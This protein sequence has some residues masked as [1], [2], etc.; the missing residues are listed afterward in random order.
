M[1]DTNCKDGALDG[2]SVPRMQ[3]GFLFARCVCGHLR[4]VETTTVTGSPACEHCGATTADGLIHGPDRDALVAMM[5]RPPKATD[6]DNV[7]YF[8]RSGNLIK[9]GTT[10]A[11]WT[12]MANLGHPELLGVIP[13]GYQVERQHHE[14]FTTDKVHGEV[15]RA[16][17][18]LLA[19]IDQHC[20]HPDP[21]EPKPKAA[22]DPTWQTPGWMRISP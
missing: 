12:R 16:S 5:H 8:A 18:R 20:A 10:R 4:K 2:C 17:D 1:L 7:V 6:S 14:M 11:L 9:I 22:G 3:D 15:F 19:Y 13:G 21:P